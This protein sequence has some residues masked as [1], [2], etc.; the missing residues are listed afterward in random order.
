M[1]GDP[2]TRAYLV[3]LEAYWAAA[4][5]GENDGKNQPKP[6]NADVAWEVASLCAKSIAA[7]LDYKKTGKLPD[8]D[9]GPSTAAQLEAAAMI[10]QQ[11]DT[12]WAGRS[13]T[14]PHQGGAQGDR[15]ADQAARGD[16][17]TRRREK[18]AAPT[19]NRK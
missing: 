6:P 3:G 1:T 2:E 13:P 12:R 5:R 7:L 9:W 17:T 15:R 10:A 11:E 14:A 4:E 18:H 16:N 8:F 19:G